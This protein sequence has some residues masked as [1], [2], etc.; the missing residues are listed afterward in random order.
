MK[1]YR[2]ISCCNVLYKLIS[3]ILANRL[4]AFLPD[5]IA[6]NQSAFIKDRLLMENLLLATELVKEYH[7]ETI[8]SRCALKIDIPKAF[9]SV[10][11][12]FL[13]NILKALNIP[14]KFIHWIT[15]C[16][17]TTSFSVQ[18]N[19][20]LAG[21]F[22]SKRGLRQ[23][24][25]LSPYLFVMC[26][27]VLS[28]LLDRAAASRLLGYH[29]R[30]SSMQLTH[31]CFADDIM[32]FSDGKQSSLE[33]LLAV[34]KEFE[35]ISGLS[36]SLE[37]STIYLAGVSSSMR[38]TLLAHF[39]FESASLPVRYLGLPLLTRMMTPADCTPLIEKIRQRISS[40]KHRFLSF[41]GRLQ[42]LSSS[43]QELSSKKNKL[44]WSDV[45]LPKV[46]GGLGLRSL[47]EANKV[48]CFKLIWR[49]VSGSSSLW[50]NWVQRELLLSASFWSDP[51]TTSMGSWMWR[52]LLK[53]RSQAKSFHM[54][55]VCSGLQ[56]SFWF[57]HWCPLGRLF[58]LLGS[59]G[60]IAMGI[61]SSA[62]VGLVVSTH[63][64]RRHHL[65][66]LNKVE[67]EIT[68]LRDRG[69]SQGKD[70]SLWRQS[71]L[72]YKPR[73]SS[74]DTW[75]QLRHPRQTVNWYRGIWFSGS[76]PKHSFILWLAAKNRL[77]TGDRLATWNRGV[78]TAC[79]FCQAPMETLEHLFFTCSYTSWVWA[80][81]SRKL[82]ESHHSA[83]FSQ[84]LTLLSSTTIT[85][86]AL[87]IL[88]L[89]FQGTLHTV[90]LERNRR[91]HGEHP[92]SSDHM[93][94]FLDRLMR[95]K[96]LS[97]QRLSSPKHANALH[98]WL[99]TRF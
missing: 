70:V 97:I 10:Q 34:F 20:E 29:P 42:L 59:R 38:D 58:D 11:W 21:Y 82:S 56:T 91:R 19:G 49:L 47:A 36:I 61:P 7:K 22:Q 69:L 80:D 63:R 92:T 2:P 95:N 76:I 43:G 71:N 31:L 44:A 52:K 99:A 24:C 14:D 87:F 53:Y 78:D 84:L 79:V 96:L 33:G 68:N 64:H 13:L 48:S 90:W 50:I 8:S 25:S 73:F 28:A 60:F 46:E 83:S 26:M 93:V 12:P 37:K 30:C 85:G 67:L 72:Q 27:N 5:F 16:I 17:T 55:E 39:P 9:D 75:Q 40:W 1:D 62:T 77:M 4:K 65:D 81:L 32:V 98:V 15:L 3:K 74:S 94:Q 18:I 54:M 57:D 86:P 35:A 89:V 51:D 6:P 23:G 41:A 66:L 88:R 45:C